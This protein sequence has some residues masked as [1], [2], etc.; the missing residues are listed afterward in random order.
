MAHELSQMLAEI[1]ST[2]QTQL[3][4]MIP[5]SNS[6]HRDF[7]RCRCYSPTVRR[8]CSP[9]KNTLCSSQGKR[10]QRIDSSVNGNAG[11]NGSASS[12]NLEDS[13]GVQIERV[14][15]QKVEKLLILLVEKLELPPQCLTCAF[16][17][18]ER[19][20]KPMLQQRLVVSIYTIEK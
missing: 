19:C 2:F 18:I 1:V 5:M 15:A 6:R 10:Q 13:E 4:P 16:V 14:V 20:L 8:E 9:N 12:R 17:L 11:Q 3:Q 7:V